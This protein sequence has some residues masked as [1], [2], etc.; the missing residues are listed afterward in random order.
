MHIFRDTPQAI[1]FAYVI[2]QYP[3]GPKSSLSGAVRA[4]T[5]EV[6]RSGIDFGNLTPT[7]IHDECTRIRK[8]VTEYL[9]NHEAAALI[10]KFTHDRREKDGAIKAIGNHIGPALWGAINDR[11]LIFAIVERHYI[12]EQDRTPAWSLRAMADKFKVSKDRVQRVARVFEQYAQQLETV[13]MDNL[14]RKFEEKS[15]IKTKENKND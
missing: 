14:R 15:L 7:E 11:A 6:S 1:H 4:A 2:E 3:A 5:A 8:A 9:P 12:P 13:A 10:A